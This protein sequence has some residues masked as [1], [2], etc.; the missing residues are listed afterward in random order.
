MPQANE[1]AYAK[2][3]ICQM[4]SAFNWNWNWN[5]DCAPVNLI[6]ID[7]VNS[8]GATKIKLAFYL[9][10]A[11]SSRKHLHQLVWLCEINWNWYESASY[12][13][14]NQLPMNR[15]KYFKLFKC[16]AKKNNGS[17]SDKCVNISIIFN[18]MSY[19]PSV[20]FSAKW[21]VMFS[22]KFCRH[23][24]LIP[25]LTWLMTFLLNQI[26][27]HKMQKKRSFASKKMK[28]TL[29]IVSGSCLSNWLGTNIINHK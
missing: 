28:R 11:N 10:C 6:N 24:N 5:E 13:I 12:H 18:W 1:I 20:P 4:S 21:F 27:N 25:V 26:E 14:I 3:S 7:L 2:M 19:Y 17:R 16:D 29:N 22:L 8:V 23:R 9:C 15:F